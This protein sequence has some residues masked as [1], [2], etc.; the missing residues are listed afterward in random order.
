MPA[1]TTMTAEMLLHAYHDAHPGATT[2]TFAAWQ[3]VGDAAHR[4][5][6]ELLADWVSREARGEVALDVA[7]G[8]GYL[9]E[10]LLAQ[11]HPPAAVIGV[12]ASEAEL[13]VARR[14]RSLKRGVAL[15]HGRAQDLLLPT[16]EVQAVACHMALMLMDPLEPVL[17]SIARVLTDDGALGAI[18]A[19][20]THDPVSQGFLAHL[21]AL[22]SAPP[23]TLGDPRAFSAEG[24]REL[25]SPHFAHIEIS[26]HTLARTASPEQIWQDLSARYD[27]FLLDPE[28]REALHTAFLADLADPTAPI[29]VTLQIHFVQAWRGRQSKNQPVH[30]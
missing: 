6:Y 4:S 19:A 10:R 13:K 11:P 26:A 18:V 22:R 23:P 15:H 3:V 1:M 12:D 17:E 16:G 24:L 20:G 7:C 8:D 14:R 29:T 9:L 2:Q 30:Q 27:V 28:A 25:L 5:S 21:R